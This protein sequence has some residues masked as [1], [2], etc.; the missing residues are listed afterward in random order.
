MNLFGYT[1]TFSVAAALGGANS[2]VTVDISGR[3]LERARR[4]FELA[5]VELSSLHE[6]VRADVTEWLERAL[7]RER[8]G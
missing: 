2:T 4:N 5:G 1:A 7:R 6:F 3:A 8:A